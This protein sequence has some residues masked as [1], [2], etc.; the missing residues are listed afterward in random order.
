VRV[1]MSCVMVPIW[2]FV[3][4]RRKGAARRRSSNGIR[5]VER[6]IFDS[7]SCDVENLPLTL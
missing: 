5:I 7:F 6:A 2:A 3:S 4:C 1:K